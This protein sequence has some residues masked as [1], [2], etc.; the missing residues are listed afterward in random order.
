MRAAAV[1]LGLLGLACG[2]TTEDTGSS[3]NP[4]GSGGVGGSGSGAGSGPAGLG[5]E[6][7][8]SGSAAGAAGGATGESCTP[9][10]VQE[11]R[12]DGFCFGTRKCVGS[13]WSECNCPGGTGGGGQWA[14]GSSATCDGT[15]CEGS[16]LPAARW[17]IDACCVSDRPGECGLDMTLSDLH[18]GMSFRHDCQLASRA[19]AVSEQCPNHSPETGE[20]EEYQGCCRPTGECGVFVINAGLGCV[21]RTEIGLDPIDC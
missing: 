12:G 6:S 11:C 8:A 2:G 5:G 15:S 9:P 7:G 4:G 18:L 21:P 16:Y 14:P 20:P 10:A 13:S 17:S 3:S 1:A 19:G